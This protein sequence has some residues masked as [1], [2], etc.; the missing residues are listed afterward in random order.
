MRRWLKRLAVALLVLLLVPVVAIGALRLALGTDTGARLAVEAVNRALAGQGVAIGGLAGAFPERLA[1]ESLEIQDRDG[2]WLRAEAIALRWRPVRLALRELAIAELVAGRIAVDRRPVGRS[3]PAAGGRTGGAGALPLPLG[4]TLD[5]V[6]VDRLTLADPVIGTQVAAQVTGAAALPRD[7]SGATLVVSARRL[8]GVPGSLEVDLGLDLTDLTAR[9]D[10]SAEEPA[11]GVL[12]RLVGL[13]DLPP[14]RIALAGSG[15]LDDLTVAGRIDAHAL[16]TARLQ[17]GLSR[18]D[19]PR[20]GRHLAL[21]ATLDP[22]PAIPSE[23]APLIGEQARL[24]LDATVDRTFDAVTVDDLSLST[25]AVA[26]GGTGRLETATLSFVADAGFSADAAAVTG[27]M[28]ELRWTG[29]LTGTVAANGRLEDLQA[30]I[31][32]AVAGLASGERQRTG[33]VSVRALVERVDGRTTA[34]AD[35]SVADP[36]VGVPAVDALLA[37]EATLSTALDLEG[38]TLAVRQAVMTLPGADLTARL[39]GRLDLAERRGAGTLAVDLGTLS[40]LDRFTVAALTGAA[41]ATAD[42]SLDAAGITARLQVAVAG[43]G[44]LPEPLPGLLG[45]SPALRTT[46]AAGFDGAVSLDATS[47]SGAAVS[48][49]GEGRLAAGSVEGVASVTVSDLAALATPLGGDLI[50]TVGASGP[51]AAPDLSLSAVLPTGSIAGTAVRDLALDAVATPAMPAGGVGPP[52]WSVTVDGAGRIAGLATGLTLRAER[53]SAADTGPVALGLTAPGATA[54]ARLR[55]QADAGPSGTATV[56][57]SDLTALTAPWTGGAVGGRGAVRVG[58][59]PQA[60]EVSAVARDLVGPSLTGQTVSLAAR[61]TDPFTAPAVDARLDAVGTAAAVVVETAALTVR[62]RPSDLAVSLATAGTALAQPFTLVGDAAVQG[63]TGN[64]PTIDLTRLD[65]RI[66]GGAI[67]LADPVRIAG[68]DGAFAWSPLT[69]TSPDGAVTVSGAWPP[70]RTDLVLTV[71]GVRPAML[72]WVGPVPPVDGRLDGTARLSGGSADRRAAVALALT[73]LSPTDPG[74][75]ALGAGEVRLD[76][77]WDGTRATA[78]GIVQSPRLGTVA[79]RAAIDAPNDQGWPRIA[80]DAPL[81]AAI[82]GTVD[83]AALTPLLAAE[84]SRIGGEATVDLTLSGPLSGPQADGAVTVRDGSLASAVTGLRLADLTVRLVG[85]TTGLVIEEARA[86]TAGGGTI[87]AAGTLGLGPDLPADLALTMDDA[88]LAD[89]DLV[90]ARLDGA[91]SLTGSVRDRPRLAG[92]ITSDRIIVRLPDQLPATAPP[93][94]VSERGGTASL[95]PPDPGDGAP[96]LVT[97]LDVTVALPGRVFVRGRGLEAELAGDLTVT[98]TTAAPQV[99]GAVRL[100]RGQ[101]SL[102]GSAITLT[103]GA[104]IFDGGPPT[105]PRIDLVARRQTGDATVRV[106]V[107][108]RA[109]APAIVFAADPPLPEDEVLA[110]LLFGVPATALTAAQAVQ[111]G[112]AASQ[113]SGLGGGG[114]DLVGQV[115]S[116][117]GLDRLDVA[118][119]PETGTASVAAEARVTERITVGVE[120]GTAAQS[121]RARVEF[122]LT[123]DLALEAETGTDAQS[124]FGLRWQREY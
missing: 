27:V 66:G 77:R 55:W 104:V 58:L 65:G 2:V 80:P 14:L 103:D 121:S 25:A 11:G 79:A 112:L 38:A 87:A 54:E 63:L 23:L 50:A 52:A 34:T 57:A 114:P 107:S 26:L 94:P 33:P 24:A 1:L 118:A 36:A 93:I 32:L 76:A 92:S 47:L 117:L 10:V 49:A 90:Q 119:D 120:Q 39:S 61:V 40:A 41:E 122:E 67:T 109:G 13:P 5:R 108:G 83:L 81:S 8:D 116:T 102:A 98:G 42:W 53:V 62:G 60:L 31:D 110:R 12:A 44:G 115:R 17:A 88:L 29:P 7:G 45:P 56:T 51:L 64:R 84:G 78:D 99:D 71:S 72:G 82:D 4:L 18:S 68:E 111:L 106:E 124:R 37:G 9:I 105:D 6:R 89:L 75:A 100:V 16:G 86:R 19:D 30:S 123:P 48:L 95:P 113:L 101:L 28:P 97:D 3:D 35:L 46:V 85:D 20:D 70:E 91:L 74:L 22:G 15:S 21:T 73:G 69:L 96:P 43:L 59:T